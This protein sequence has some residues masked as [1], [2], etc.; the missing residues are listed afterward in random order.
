MVL[1]AK[2]ADNMK[3]GIL[4]MTIDQLGANKFVLIVDDE[5]I[6]RDVISYDFKK[7]GFTVFTSCDGV[8]AMDILKNHHIDVVISDIQMPRCDGISLLEKIR[9]TNSLNPIFLFMSGF[10]LYTQGQIEEMGALTLLSKP[11]DRKE[12]FRIVEEALST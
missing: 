9:N 10:S 7:R 12:M 2:Y 4:H 6:L 11:I 3:R 5:K 8:E 1:G